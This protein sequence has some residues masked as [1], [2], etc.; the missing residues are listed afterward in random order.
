[1]ASFI[2]V[3]S[4][5]LLLRASAVPSLSPPS[6]KPITQFK[7]LCW[8]W[9]LKCTSK[10][11]A[12]P[13]FETAK[14]ASSF[15]LSSVSTYNWCAA[16]GGIG[17]LETAYLTYLKLTDSDAF[18]PVGGGSCGDVLNSDYAVVFGIPLPAIGMVAYGL[19]AALGFQLPVKNLPFGIGESNGRLILL[20]STTSMAAASAYFLYILSS[21]FSGASCSYCL[22]SAFLSFSLFFITLKDFGL[23]E[24]QKVLGLQLCIVSLVLFALN[25]SYGT[26]PPVSSSL[27]EIELPYFTSE[28]TTSSSPFAVSL[29]RHL[30]SIGAKMYGAFWCSHCLEQKQMFGKEASGILDYEECF[31]DGYRKGTKI[32]KA[33]ADAKI[34]GFPTWVINGEVLSGEKE[35]SELAQL[36]GFEFN[37]LSQPS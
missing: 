28:I 4:P 29:A 25:T 35:L 13:E 15:P 10:E 9:R 36:S 24:I 32:A 33:C 1:M 37:E 6:L 3:S 34:E 2:N 27:A 30:H 20:A 18:C 11:D 5:P 7:G 12:E 22:L 19:V 14:P 8:R 26:S 31:P 17:F 16:L 21:K 23:Q